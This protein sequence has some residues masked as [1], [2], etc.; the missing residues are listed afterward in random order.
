MTADGML[1]RAPGCAKPICSTKV[2]SSV[3]AKKLCQN[4]DL[5]FTSSKFQRFWQSKS[6]GQVV[7]LTRPTAGKVLSAVGV[8]FGS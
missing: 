3:I 7:E 1:A 6:P 2:P 4:P 5:A 8:V